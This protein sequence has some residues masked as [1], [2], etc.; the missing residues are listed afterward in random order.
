MAEEEHDC[1]SIEESNASIR[2]DIKEFGL[3][4]LMIRSYGYLPSFAYSIGLYET[5]GHPE[6]ICIGLKNATAHQI[7][8]DAA[9]QIKNGEKF[10]HGDISNEIF[11]N[12][13]AGF[14][15]VDPRNIDDYFGTA[16][17]YY[18]HSD[19][20][21]IQLVWTDR[22]DKFPWEEDFEDDFKYIQPL[23]DRNADFKFNE[24][25]NLAIFTTRQ[26]LE[27][28]KPI[29]RIVHDHN[30]D[31]QFLPGDQIPSDVRIVALEQMTLRDNTL[32]EVFD[33]NYGERAEREFIG[34]PWTRTKFE[35]EPE[36]EED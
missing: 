5:Y 33:L 1:P 13:K 31:W 6:I 18:G 14:L 2:K 24:A 36:E 21:A 25:K 15:S 32:N 9:E 29:L 8:N 16:I 11:E 23:L 26:W 30:G 10:K 20:P 17:N 28:D 4:V 27:K 34:G 7:I 22:N 19:F 3:Q 12:G 35:E